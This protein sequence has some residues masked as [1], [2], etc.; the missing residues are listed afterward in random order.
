MGV[1]APCRPLEVLPPPAGRSRYA[2]HNW[3]LMA[4]VRSWDYYKVRLWHLSVSFQ[5][6]YRGF[7]YLGL[8]QG[9][10]MKSFCPLDCLSLSFLQCRSTLTSAS[11]P[12]SEL[13]TPP[14]PPRNSPTHFLVDTQ[15]HFGS[16]AYVPCDND[17][18]WGDV[19]RKQ[20][21]KV[22]FILY[23]FLYHSWSR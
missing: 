19:M 9:G 6:Y 23:Y 20:Y 1:H 4:S 14:L 8:L 7:L 18:A 15:V 12:P 22:P 3:D 17:T 11:L 2:G 5:S 16:D 10:L 21:V 13:A